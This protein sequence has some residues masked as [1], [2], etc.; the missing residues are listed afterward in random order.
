MKTTTI[1]YTKYK[2]DITIPTIVIL[3]EI[4]PRFS[5]LAHYFVKLN[6][7]QGAPVS[8]L[9]HKVRSIASLIDYY[10]LNTLK[11]MTAS[12]CRLFLDN[13][14]K[15]RINGTVQGWETLSQAQAI[16]NLHDIEEF[17]QWVSRHAEVVKDTADE[18]FANT[19]KESF[20]FLNRTQNSFLFHNRHKKNLKLSLGISG[21]SGKV[22]KSFPVDKVMDLINSVSN[23]RDK[24]AYILMAFGGRR[25]SEVLHMFVSDFSTHD[26]QLRVII[27]HP[28]HSLYQWKDDGVIKR[29]T[30][31]EY[32]NEV[33]NNL[34]RNKLG[35][36]TLYVGWRGLRFEKPELS[37]SE[38]YFVGAIENYLLNLH[39]EYM[40]VRKNFL[41]TPYY[42][43]T[44]K[45]EPLS[46]RGLLDKFDWSCKKIG[47]EIDS[48]LDHGV[49]TYGLRHFYG[50]Y[51]SKV[52]KLESLI[53]Q[54]LIG[55]TSQQFSKK[56]EN[57][58]EEI[59]K[60]LEKIN[61]EVKMIGSRH[62]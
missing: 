53:V 9:T 21:N 14:S 4:N 18:D 8:T 27:A 29:G 56:Y 19:V 45:G 43:V 58:K 13:Y 24:I 12:D 7:E 5:N 49:H 10:E 32:L 46:Y 20:T 59:F 52:L 28:E 60:E 15:A 61:P 48:N 47:L 36:T 37:M 30:R 22:V 44:D 31:S 40:Q 11:G 34:P 38:V 3:D 41:D 35:K 42:F 16:K 17:S 57:N 51:C 25:I 6:L 23:P 62:D 50:F 33:F 54:K 39:L 26:N 1:V 55:H 2:K